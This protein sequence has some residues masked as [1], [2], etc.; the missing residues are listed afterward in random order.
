MPRLARA[1]V[2]GGLAVGRGVGVE[3]DGE[4]GGWRL[5]VS[6]GG[7]VL[8]DLRVV[9]G[10]GAGGG[11]LGVGEVRVGVRAAGV[12]FR[13]VLI[14]LGM[15]PGDAAVGSEGAGVVLEVGPDVS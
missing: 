6:G 13:D 5:G 11:A 14:A 4:A 15:Y 12:N 8:E 1:G 2:N 3:A 9:S 10:E 7:G